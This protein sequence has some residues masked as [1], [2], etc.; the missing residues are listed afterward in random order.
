MKGAQ[1]ADNISPKD[2]KKTPAPVRR[3]LQRTIRLIWES[4]E[5][6][7]TLR[8]SLLDGPDPKGIGLSATPKLSE[9]AKK[10]TTKKRKRKKKA[11]K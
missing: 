1:S 5:S 9:L 2:L 4:R 11:G 3:L 6:W 7:H 10:K 8:F